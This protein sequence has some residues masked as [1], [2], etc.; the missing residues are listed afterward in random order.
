MN[1]YH[2]LR[3][4]TNGVT[5]LTSPMSAPLPPTQA[6]AQ[7][8]DDHGHGGLE[9]LAAATHV[10]GR[11]PPHS[12]PRALPLATLHPLRSQS[13][14]QLHIDVDSP[15]SITHMGGDDEVHTPHGA[16]PDPAEGT[17]LSRPVPP[18]IDPSSR[19]QWRRKAHR[20]L[21]SKQVHL[22]IITLVIL[23]LI[24]VITEIFIGVRPKGPI[25]STRS[26]CRHA[27]WEA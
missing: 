20:I 25:E 17:F 7:A 9:A 24:V 26:A 19:T 8:A 11:D 12:H 14:P 6:Q 27:T 4:A 22:V 16:E 2:T 21:E 1:N 18:A 5:A 15:S 10:C 3:V 13:M 23:D